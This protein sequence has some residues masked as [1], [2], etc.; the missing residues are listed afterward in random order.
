MPD[1]MAPVPK[2]TPR[3]RQMM[4]AVARGCS[5]RE[6]AGELGLSQQTVKNQLSVLFQKLHVR[7]RLQLA[8]YAQR[9]GLHP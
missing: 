2:L 6:I 5:N 3:E 8:I 7:N 1:M 9:H 4:G